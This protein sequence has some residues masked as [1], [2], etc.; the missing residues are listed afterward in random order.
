[1]NRTT[2]VTTFA[3]TIPAVDRRADQ[4]GAGAATVVRLLRAG[5]TPAAAQLMHSRGM[6][7]T[8]AVDLLRVY[9]PRAPRSQRSSTHHS[10][11]E[12]APHWRTE[13]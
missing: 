13:Q 11:P 1:M 12:P 8:T 5:K 3:D 7:L 4:V 9:G 6:S 2:A 10:R